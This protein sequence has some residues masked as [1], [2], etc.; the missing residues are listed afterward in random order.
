MDERI[1][2]H[3]RV[4]TKWPILH[5]GE[6]PAIDLD[7]WRLRLF[8][9]VKQE[10][11]WDWES[12]T[13]LE[14]ARYTSD[15]HCVTGWSRLENTWEGVKATTLLSQVELLPT[16]RYVMI[17]AEQGFTTNL[18]LED[19]MAEGVL[20]AWAHN[21]QTLTPAH[22]WPLRLVVPHLYFW[23]SAK[24]VTGVELIAENHPGFWE[25]H[26]YHMHGDPWKEERF[27]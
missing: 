4:T 23:K 9:L 18:P 25:Q 6:I 1:P 26:G 7:T 12:F 15:I 19:F 8:G 2:P 11:V 13:Q 24:W 21:G 5:Y 17:H 10:K 22:G 27:G 3:Q 16:A 20:F 14:R